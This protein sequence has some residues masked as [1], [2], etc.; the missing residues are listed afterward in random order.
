MDPYKLALEGKSCNK[1]TPGAKATNDY[2]TL[3]LLLSLTL[4][5]YS[6]KGY[7]VLI[8]MFI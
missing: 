5:V 8:P 6:L 1:G 7:Q 4:A 3:Y 2:R